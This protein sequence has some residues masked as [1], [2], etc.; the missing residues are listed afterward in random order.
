VTTTQPLTKSS[1]RRGLG[2][3]SIAWICGALFTAAVSAEH[4][5]PNPGEYEVTTSSNFNNTPVTMTTTNC[6]TAEDLDQ[7][8]AKIF[9]DSAASENCDM[10]EFQMADGVLLMNMSCNADDGGMEMTTEGAYTETGYSMNSTITINAGGTTITTEASIT[11][12]RIGD[13]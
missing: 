12:T 7:D 1:R 10:S 4:H 3:R 6:I 13:C 9:A 8:P 2:I 11:A 5:R